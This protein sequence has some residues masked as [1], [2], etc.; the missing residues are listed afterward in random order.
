MFNPPLLL[1]K[2]F[3]SPF[4]IVCPVLALAPNQS[5]DRSYI[6][7]QTFCLCPDNGHTLVPVVQLTRSLDHHTPDI[8]SHQ[9]HLC[10]HNRRRLRAHRLY[11][12][13]SL[14]PPPGVNRVAKIE[15]GDRSALV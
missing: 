11:S 12:I 1:C 15:N 14:P 7:K 9:R 2:V 3:H 13:A 6:G 8:G 10:P 4:P 5:P